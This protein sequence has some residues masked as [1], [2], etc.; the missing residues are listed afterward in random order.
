MKHHVLWDSKHISQAGRRARG[1]G[2]RGEGRTRAAEGHYTTHSY[3]PEGADPDHD[4]KGR[5]SE[6]CGL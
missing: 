5:N 1:A 3:G 4:D 2:V 6:N